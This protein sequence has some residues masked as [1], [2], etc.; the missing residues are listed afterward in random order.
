MLRS[1]TPVPRATWNIS[2]VLNITIVS[3]VYFHQDLVR[4]RVYNGPGI[5]LGVEYL[6]EAHNFNVTLQYLGNDSIHSTSDMVANV[7]QVTDFYYNKWDRNGI[8]A[9]VL[10]GMMKMFDRQREHHN[11]DA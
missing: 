10:P 9:M 6:R 5:E 1:L 4:S 3:Y 7:Y 11:V 2:P 8:L